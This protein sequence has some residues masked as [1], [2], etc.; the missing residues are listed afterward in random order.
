MTTPHSTM[1]FFYY[2]RNK[3]MGC[4]HSMNTPHRAPTAGC[5]TTPP[6]FIGSSH[7]MNTPYTSICVVV[8]GKP[9]V[10][11]VVIP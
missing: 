2:E 5:M 8:L 4:G 7:A 10:K 9:M 1:P 3:G 11:G 6:N